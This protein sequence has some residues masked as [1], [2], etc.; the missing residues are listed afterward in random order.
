M[1]LNELQRDTISNMICVCDAL[2]YNR[3]TEIE[4]LAEYTDMNFEFLQNVLETI[5][6]Q[7]DAEQDE[8]IFD[9]LDIAKA[10]AE[11]RAETLDDLGEYHEN[12]YIEISDLL[13]S[14]LTQDTEEV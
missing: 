10:I 5:P 2:G 4:E 13:F 14:I 7:D 12:G 11:D 6:T 1:K 8:A 9:A 3:V